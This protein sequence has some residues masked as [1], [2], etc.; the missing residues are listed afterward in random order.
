MPH[1][2]DPAKKDFLHSEQRRIMHSPADILSEVNLKEGDILIDIGAGTGY[3]SIPAAKIVGPAGR[4]IAVDISTEMLRDLEKRAAEEGIG[5]I[6]AKVSSEYDFVT[7][8]DI[9]DHALA[10]MVVHEVDDKTR[11]LKNIHDILK[12]G[13]T[14][15]ILEW[16]LNPT[17]FTH[18]PPAAHRIKQ[19]ELTQYLANAGF[20]QIKI[21]TLNDHQYI[22][23]A[24]A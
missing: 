13:G 21:K 24:I 4:V 3:L 23:H 16:D 9:G 7:G 17:S 19:D 5:N 22:C 15:T 20:D 8:P 2:F 10:S 14:L 18:G 6:E 11:F 12:T 1:K